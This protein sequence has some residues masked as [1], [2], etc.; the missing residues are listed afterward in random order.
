M[1]AVVIGVADAV[2]ARIGAASLSQTVTAVRAYVPVY[3]LESMDALHV[4]VVPR[5]LEMTAQSRGSDSFAYHVDVAVQRRVPDRTPETIDP[6]MLLTEEIVDLFRGRNLDDPAAAC[7]AAANE[8][9]YDPSHLDEMTL[10]TAVVRLS[11]TMTRA[12]L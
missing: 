9:I 4:T 11:F 5:G 8:P 2:A 10:F 12:R 7:T 6:L 1:S 3:D